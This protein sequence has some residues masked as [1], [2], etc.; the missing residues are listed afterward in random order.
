MNKT[1]IVLP[2]LLSLMSLN[3][4]ASPSIIPANWEAHP[5]IHLR[6][7]HAT[8]SPT[9][10]SPA[11][12]LKAYNFPTNLN[13]AG[14]TIAIVDAYDDP[15][16]EADLNT[17]SSAFGL[18]ACTTANGCFQKIYENGTAP[19]ASTTWGMEISL[20]VEWAHAI[21]PLAKIILIEAADNSMGLYNAI[22]IATQHHASVISCSWGGPE[23]NGESSLDYIFANSTVP[24]VVSSGD[25]GAGVTYPAAS[26]YVLSIGGTYLKLDANGNYLNETAWSGSAGGISSYEKA[27]SNQL[28]YP[29]P[30]N[31]TGGRDVP[32]VSIIASPAS[33]VSIYDSYGHN[34]WLVVGGTSIGAPIWSAVIANANSGATT[35]LAANISSLIYKAAT[36]SYATIYTD[37]SS[38]SNGTCGYYC[39]STS[40]YDYVTGLGTPKVTALIAYLNNPGQL[41]VRANPTLTYTPTSQSGTAGAILNYTLSVTNNDTLAC[42]G[43]TF[44]FNTTSSYGISQTLSQN[45]ITVAPGVTATVIDHASSASNVGSGT[46]NISVTA[47]NTSATSYKTTAVG[48]YNVTGTCVRGNPI[49]TITPNAQSTTGLK[50]VTYSVS[51][52]NTDSA[53]CGYSIFGFSA[54]S[55]PYGMI[56]FMEP[57]NLVSYPGTSAN[58]ILTVTP[59][60][61][62]QAAA[63]SI[64]VTGGAAITTQAVTILNYSPK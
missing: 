29:L 58:S 28:N 19:T 2:L 6:S 8:S 34:G 55:N 23:F 44:G 63:Y 5:P 33:G 40:G 53:A 24:I 9:G 32:D 21:A 41:C 35:P 42:G 61:G 10:M 1:K 56:T 11:Q 7:M 51:I 45:T 64:L 20:D 39:Q 3:V 22:S 31:P 47:N 37:V 52:Q 13:G 49:I 18:P 59:T 38:G 46:Y 17:F 27:P 16:I 26:P 60:S 12:I 15:N 14:Q 25:S 62:L 50:P 57:Y 43:S 54:S 4:V 30:Q 48:I 36:Q